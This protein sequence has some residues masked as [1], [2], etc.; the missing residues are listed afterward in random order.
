MA[1]TIE[2]VTDIDL[3][4]NKIECAKLTITDT[5]TPFT[6]KNLMTSGKDY[7][8]SLY[9]KN[10]NSS[11]ISV[12]G[13]E[14]TSEKTWTRKYV[15]FTATG[16]D[17]SIIFKSTGT[18][19]FYNTQL[20]T[21]KVCSDWTPNPQDASDDI[22]NAT[23]IAEQTADK[24][25][26]IVKS[27]T[28]SSNFELTDRTIN[29]ISENINLDGVVTFVNTAK[30]N[31]KR[32]LYDTD[33]S[34]FENLSSSD[35]YYSK[36]NGVTSVVIDNSVAYNKDKSLKITY[37]NANLNTR[38]TPLYL[39]NSKNDYGCVRVEAGKK[40]LL[41]CYVKS[42]TPDKQIFM[43]DFQ[44]HNTPDNSTNGL[45]LSKISINQL[46]GSSN[47]VSLS[48]TWTRAVCAIETN[49][50]ET[51]LY[52]SIVPLIWG[53][54][55]NPTK[56]TF[57]VWID[58][59]MLE[60]VS[61][62]SDQPGVYIE[63][64]EVV[65]DG[66]SI[67]AN[68]ITA[69]A[70]NTNSIMSRNYS[71]LDDGSVAS[72]SFLN[73]GDGSFKSKYLN[74]DETGKITA[75]G[76]KIG[77]YDI[78]DTYLKTNNGENTSGI[79]GNQAFWAGK[80]NSDS[81][82]F[83]VSYDGKLTSLSGNI[84]GWNISSDG[85][86]NNDNVAF[87][88]TK[89]N[90]KKLYD[91]EISNNIFFGQ[92]KLTTFNKE[93][94]QQTLGDSS[95]SKTYDV[96]TINGTIISDASI[97]L[98]L[99]EYCGSQN[100]EFGTYGLV[101]K[102]NKISFREYDD[103]GRQTLIDADRTLLQPYSIKS[104]NIQTKYLNIKGNIIATGGNIDGNL[105]VNKIL[106]SGRYTWEGKE[107]NY[108]SSSDYNGA[109][110]TYYYSNGYHAFYVDYKEK[111]VGTGTQSTGMLWINSNGLSM[112]GETGLYSS[113]M[114]G[115]VARYYVAG[116]TKST[117]I[118]NND[119]A[120][121]IYGSSVWANKS[122]S[123]SD[124]R[125]KKDFCSLDKFEDL[126]MKLQPVS[127]KYVD[128]YDKS[129]DIYFGLKAQTTE[130]LFKDINENPDDYAMFNKFGIDHNDIKKRLGHDVDF[131]EEHGLD[132]TNMI[133]LNTHMIQKTRKELEE[134]KK[135][136]Q[137]LKQIIATRLGIVE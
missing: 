36:D 61:S 49:K 2:K 81:A 33:Y 56:E 68:T 79:G 100:S 29:L 5:S 95:N 115:Y 24:F 114:S 113:T 99:S 108:I 87:D 28:S 26:W 45:Y 4:G 101:L 109:T 76:G 9:L 11:P 8:F 16:T 97:E 123:T 35:I 132:Y 86:Y 128:G 63:K 89:H 18:Y 10:S 15:A 47:T 105:Y 65:I 118:G 12:Y 104:P 37:T 64:Q 54:P 110:N 44:S 41:S 134:L 93:F 22:E 94:I 3:N 62:V 124:E 52:W 53:T 30:G 48:S 130:K 133:A 75:T 137:K 121:R 98:F 72:G 102:G 6:M 67:L 50:N 55:G 14:L 40:Y 85:L 125:L 136:N 111:E 126:Y 83:R 25:S 13:T 34:N 84:G 74:W 88:I 17:L 116:S 21:G 7:V 71:V 51:N 43:L 19:Y 96:C 92:S 90:A 70:L 117:A 122:V 119:Y 103:N 73:L 38:V 80:D 78:T 82:P 58:C 112:S 107:Y 120:T 69:D 31:G 20:E 66:G 23:S 135:E 57:N 46:P 77:R 59:I 32:N 39:G 1:N 106:N 131:D 60:E 91:Q 129:Q 42:D 127:F 27:G